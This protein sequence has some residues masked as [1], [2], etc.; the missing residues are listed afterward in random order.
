MAFMK[1]ENLSQVLA[2][3]D[4]AIQRLGL[5]AEWV[6]DYLMTTYGKQGRSLLTEEE[7]RDFLS[8]LDIHPTPPD[9]FPQQPSEEFL[10]KVLPK[11][12]AQMQRLGLSV[13]WGRNYLI[14]TYGKRSR[15]L[16]TEEELLDFLHYLE[17]QPTPIDEST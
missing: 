9:D 11:T 1:P 6:R 8:F 16:L 13:E 15:V 2:K 3:T 14:K 17:S 4:A 12:D 10:A 7:S 5:T